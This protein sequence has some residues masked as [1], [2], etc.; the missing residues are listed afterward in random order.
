MRNNNSRLCSR[1]CRVDR[2]GS[3]RTETCAAARRIYKEV[4]CESTSEIRMR[5]GRLHRLPV[6]H[7]VKEPAV[8]TPKVFCGFITLRN[9]L[10]SRKGKPLQDIRGSEIGEQFGAG[11]GVRGGIKSSQML[12][13]CNMNDLFQG[14]GRSDCGPLDIQI[15]G[16]QQPPVCQ[17]RGRQ[18]QGRSIISKPADGAIRRQENCSESSRTD[19]EAYEPT[20]SLIMPHL[21]VL[22]LPVRSATLDWNYRGVTNQQNAPRRWGRRKKSLPPAVADGLSIVVILAKGDCQLDKFVRAR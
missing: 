10:Q 19:S 7:T 8:R 1:A 22:H 6:N 4:K 21:G 17:L 3:A 20:R 2:S 11:R 15:V 16:V 13:L 9:W 12:T 18:L 5:E 14:G